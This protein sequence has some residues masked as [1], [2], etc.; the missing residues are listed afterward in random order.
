MSSFDKG[1]ANF[2]SKL[3]SVI[4]DA[5]RSGILVIGN[6]AID[7]IRRRTRSGKG[8]SG[9]SKIKLKPLSKTYIKFRQKNSGR[10]SPFASARK[11]N[12]TFSGKMLNGLV[13]VKTQKGIIITFD[14][15]RNK[16]VAG[17]VSETRPFMDLASDEVAEV[18]KTFRK[19][20]SALVKSKTK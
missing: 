12:L 13:R 14:T 10:L 8:V 7:I 3:K 4:K 1:V 15:N 17:H 20:F 6:I 9:D 16:E 5:N 2:T 11:S 19:Y 18:A